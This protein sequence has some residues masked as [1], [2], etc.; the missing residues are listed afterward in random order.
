MSC[1]V[2]TGQVSSVHVGSGRVGSVHNRLITSG[3]L[4]ACLGRRGRGAPLR[5]FDLGRI[6]RCATVVED[7]LG[8]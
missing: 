7:A 5:G 8:A 1:Q 6:A 2:R 3:P 4:R